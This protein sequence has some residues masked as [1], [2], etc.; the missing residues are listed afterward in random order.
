MKSL[1]IVL[2][3]LGILPPALALVQR[4]RIRRLDRRVGWALE[5][6]NRRNKR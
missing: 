5:Q 1:A 6:F 4:W 2:L 3:V